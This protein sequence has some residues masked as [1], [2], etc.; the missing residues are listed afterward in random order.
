MYFVS[1]GIKKKRDLPGDERTHLYEAARN[2]T[3][4]LDGRDYHGGK[5]PNLADLSVFGVIRAIEGF[6][7]FNDLMESSS[8]MKSW[9]YRVKEAVGSPALVVS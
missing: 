4:A 5:K 8:E 6:A 9:Y 1:K 2:W 3:E 7:T